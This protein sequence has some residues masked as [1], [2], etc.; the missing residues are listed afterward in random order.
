VS[1]GLEAARYEARGLGNWGDA[2][3]VAAYCGAGWSFLLVEAAE[4]VLIALR[5]CGQTDQ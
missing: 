2:Q 4:Q 1:G 3:A 5:P